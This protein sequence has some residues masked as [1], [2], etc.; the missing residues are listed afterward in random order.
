M[1]LQSAVRPIA[2]AV[3][4]LAFWPTVE[5]RDNVPRRGPVIFAVNHISAL[6]SFLISPLSP[7][8]V[9]FM[10]KSEYFVRRGALGWLMRTA[11]V[12]TD[13]IPVSRTDSRSA[14]GSLDVAAAHLA[15]GGAFGIHPEGS[16]SRDGRL[17]RGRTGVAW[18][19][20]E[21]GAAVVPVAV[22][23]TD[24]ILPVGA[25]IPRPGRITVR[26]GQPLH[27][28]GS[29]GKTANQARRVVTD[30]IMDA[31]AKL[32][33]QERASSYADLPTD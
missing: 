29:E 16:R 6:D 3:L 33:D 24:R 19:A 20:L 15:K 9:A 8:R 32:S 12:G 21:T 22:S 27:F 18:L 28:D 7:R 26:F 1:L 4:R 5:G 25:R 10:A 13:A 17:Y 30:K 31:I 2:T 11:L 23:G 14:L